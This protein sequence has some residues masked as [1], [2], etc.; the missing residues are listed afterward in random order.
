MKQPLRIQP[1]GILPA[2]RSFT[3]ASAASRRSRASSCLVSR[4]RSERVSAIVPIYRHCRRTIFGRR[5][6]GNPRS[7]DPLSRRTILAAQARFAGRPPLHDRPP[8]HTRAPSSL[9]PQALSLARYATDAGPSVELI[10]RPTDAA[11]IVLLDLQARLIGADYI[12]RLC[13]HS[14]HCLAVPKRHR[15]AD[16][17]VTR[18]D[19]RRRSA[20]RPH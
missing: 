20:N 19:M 14:G 10:F 12:D 1:G 6:S 17:F 15:W 9:H 5:R 8:R 7:G 4:L 3:T 13:P 2:M 16:R 11:G 18:D